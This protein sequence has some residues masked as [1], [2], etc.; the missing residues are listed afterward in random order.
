MYFIRVGSSISDF[1]T[2]VMHQHPLSTLW[3][4]ARRMFYQ[5]II[6][7]GRRV[8]GEAPTFSGVVLTVEVDLLQYRYLRK[9]LAE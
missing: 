3:T 6:L 5:G 7:T 8:V 2:A 4:D 9:Y 1:S